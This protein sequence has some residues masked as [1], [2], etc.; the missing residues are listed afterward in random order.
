[1]SHPLRPT[2]PTVVATHHPWPTASVLA[3]LLLFALAVLTASCGVTE[4]EGGPPA[5]AD[6]VHA[7]WVQAVREGDTAVAE[8]LA[9]PTLPDPIAFARDAVARM[10]DYLTNPA[11]PTGPLENVS[12]EPV[13]D[14]AGRSVWQFAQKR[15][16]YRA[17]LVSREG[18]SFVSRWGQTSVSCS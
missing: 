13:A 17:E 4:P 12:V 3:V 18:R 16:C 11:S 5:S 9:D 14:G 2:N 15:W 6:A 1:M 8:R 10:Q 7:A